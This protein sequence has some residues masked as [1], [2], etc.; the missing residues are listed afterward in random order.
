MIVPRSPTST[1]RDRNP[2]R[3]SM[4][5]IVIFVKALYPFRA[6]LVD[7]LAKYSALDSPTPT[8]TTTTMKSEWPQLPV[9]LWS[10][11]ALT[12]TTTSQPRQILISITHTS[13]G[14][15]ILQRTC[16]TRVRKRH[17]ALSSPTRTTAAATPPQLAAHLH[18]PASSE[19]TNPRHCSTCNPAIPPLPS[20][21]TIHRDAGEYSPTYFPALFASLPLLLFLILKPSGSS[22]APITASPPSRIAAVAVLLTSTG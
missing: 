1:Y 8:P 6:D 22:S 14:A 20:S 3:Q 21:R 13:A 17:A 15:I 19:T 2:P 10:S 5:K 18:L 11:T 12:A 4:W 9:C 7:L 16:T